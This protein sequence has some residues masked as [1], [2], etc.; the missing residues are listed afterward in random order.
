MSR[1]HEQSIQ[2]PPYNEYYHTLMFAVQKALTEAFVLLF[3]WLKK[4]QVRGRGGGSKGGLGGGQRS[5]RVVRGLNRGLWYE[6]ESNSSTPYLR[7]DLK[8]H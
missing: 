6:V 2:H 4:R 7:E 8:L 1:F 5:E 3:F